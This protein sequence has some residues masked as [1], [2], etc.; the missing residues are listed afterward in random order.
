[1]KI[2]ALLVLAHVSGLMCDYEI[3]LQAVAAIIEDAVDVDVIQ[4][5]TTSSQSEL[6]AATVVE[7]S[8]LKLY[9]NSTDHHH[10]PVADY[11]LIIIEKD[12]EFAA[13]MAMNNF[14]S[15]QKVIVV[16]LGRKSRRLV[17]CLMNAMWTK[18]VLNVQVI[19][20]SNQRAL[21]YTYFPFRDDSC[22]QVNAVLWN[23]YRNGSF[24]LDIEQF[25]RKTDNFFRCPL[26]VAIFNAPPYMILTNSSGKLQMTGVDGELLKVLAEKLNFSI[27]H[28]IVSEELRWGQ[29]ITSNGSATGALGL[30][31]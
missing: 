13:F 31:S 21:I 29:F 8:K 26:K 17:D 15:H 25:P 27:Q 23:I 16:M 24:L 20:E 6:F 9:S 3:L 10:L 30:V 14:A 28:T 12:Y 22:G 11:T 1:M 18:F 19:T 2:V 7:N 5:T 4:V